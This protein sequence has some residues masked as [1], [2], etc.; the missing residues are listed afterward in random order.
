MSLL[1]DWGW[2]TL[3]TGQVTLKDRRFQ[4]RIC[5]YRA[6]ARLLYWL[7]Q[8]L[9]A[10]ERASVFDDIV[11]TEDVTV[12]FCVRYYIFLVLT[13]NNLLFL[14]VFRSLS[15]SPW[16]N[17]VTWRRFIIKFDNAWQELVWGA[18]PQNTFPL[19]KPNNRAD[20]FGTTCRRLI[21]IPLTTNRAMPES[22]CSLPEC[23]FYV[24]CWM[25]LVFSKILWARHSTW[26]HVRLQ[27]K[28]ISEDGQT[29]DSRGEEWTAHDGQG[30]KRIKEIR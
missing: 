23:T 18:V 7:S 19:W 16:I 9:T 15:Y 29:K 14:K 20:F 2:D 21:W 22:D 10:G 3:H 26:D 6:R 13:F 24:W 25:G 5:H 30:G 28:Q 11:Q 4:R 8:R 17:K 12:C 27:S 1:E